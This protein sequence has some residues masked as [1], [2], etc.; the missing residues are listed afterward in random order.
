MAS[1][2]CP[3]GSKNSDWISAL[4][5][6]QVSSLETPSEEWK[7]RVQLESV[8]NLK[9]SRMQEI[10]VNLL[11][12]NRIESKTFIVMTSNGLRHVKHYRLK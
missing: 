7:T 5:V 12:E 11:E 2:I 4:Q 10:L 1:G 3:L 9:R 6:A 8:F